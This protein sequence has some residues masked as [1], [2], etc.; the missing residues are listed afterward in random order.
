MMKNAEKMKTPIL[1]LYGIIDDVAG[2]FFPP[3]T[4]QNHQTA[5]RSFKQMLSNPENGMSRNPQDFRL[6]FLGDFDPD[7]GKIDSLD[8]V[9]LVCSGNEILVVGKDAK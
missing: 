9:E 3:F 6:F 4:S 1:N 8:C 7:D 2:T 5:E